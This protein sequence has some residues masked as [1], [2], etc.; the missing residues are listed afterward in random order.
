MLFNSY[1]FL[2]AFLPAVTLGVLLLQRLERRKAL[3]AFV[4][5]SSAVFYGYSSLLHLAILCAS[6]LM[7][8]QIS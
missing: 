4:I 8:H 2:F 1:L 3:F 6:I 5:L 7:N